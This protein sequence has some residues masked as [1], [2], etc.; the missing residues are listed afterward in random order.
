MVLP[1]RLPTTASNSVHAL[2]WFAF[3]SGE[4]R[5]DEALIISERLA[6]RSD[7]QHAP[8]QPTVALQHMPEQVWIAQCIAQ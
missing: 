1:P 3:T 4:L 7:Q 2:Q 8:R 6:H 5:E